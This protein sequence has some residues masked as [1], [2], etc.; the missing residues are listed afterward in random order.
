MQAKVYLKYPGMFGEKSQT[1]KG[2]GNSD[3]SSVLGPYAIASPSHFFA[4]LHSPILNASALKCAKEVGGMFN[5][6]LLAC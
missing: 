3:G 4:A 6:R 1:D 5:E 2:L